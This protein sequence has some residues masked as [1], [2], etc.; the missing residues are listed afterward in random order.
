MKQ[1]RVI[2]KYPNRRLYDTAQSR[3]IT[4]EDIRHLVVDG[5]PVQVI[6]NKTGRDITCTILLQVITE[7]EVPDEPS[8]SEDFLARIIRT[9]DSQLTG[10]L[11]NYLDVSLQLALDAR[12]KLADTEHP[13]TGNGG[14][15]TRFDRW[16][17]LQSQLVEAR[18]PEGGRHTEAREA[19]PT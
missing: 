4:L 15:K 1:S 11:S 7:M 14:N 8:M 13:T 18:L 6:E 17:E 3:Y 19:P 12:R 16:L 9:R 10:L 5:E 2:K